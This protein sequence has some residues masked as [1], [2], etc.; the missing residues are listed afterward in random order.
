MYPRN[1][2]NVSLAALALSLAASLGSAQAADDPGSRRVRIRARYSAGAVE[3]SLAGARRRL[4]RPTCQR[5]FSEF[6]DVKGRPLRDALD[7]KSTSGPEHLR[8]LIFYDGSP[9]PPCDRAGTLAFTSPGSP[10]VFVCTARFT[11]TA[12]RNPF[13]A[14][15]ALIHEALHTLGLGENP[16]T[17]AAITSRVMRRCGE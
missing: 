11:S 4:Q 12:L 8:S 5:V 3:R 15:A 1:A 6:A 10:I 7:E 13:L 14:E 16:P 9:Q 2:G 17:S